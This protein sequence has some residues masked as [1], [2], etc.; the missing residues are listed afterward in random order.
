M[1]GDAMGKWLWSVLN[2]REVRRFMFHR[3]TR[4]DDDERRRAT[5]IRANA[6]GRT[7][8]RDG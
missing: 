8:E 4:D 2:G 3:C 1:W 7:G 5:R 6:N